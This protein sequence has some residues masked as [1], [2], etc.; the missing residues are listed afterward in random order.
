MIVGLDFLV[1]VGLTIEL[2]ES[3]SESDSPKSST[4]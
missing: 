4:T 2:S 3:V 1:T